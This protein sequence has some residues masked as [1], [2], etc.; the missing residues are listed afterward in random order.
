MAVMPIKEI[1]DPVLR[2]EAKKVKTVDDNTRELIKNL[3]DTLRENDGLGL[4]ANQIGILQ[5][6][7]VVEVENELLKI[8]NPEII[9]KKG[10]EIGEEGC[11]S[12]PGKQGPVSRAK[13]ITLSYQNEQGLEVE[14]TFTD[15]V[16]RVI[17]HEIDHLQGKLFV[18]KIVDI[19]SNLEIDD[20]ARELD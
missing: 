2:T 3:I 18:D 17:Q 1:G 12:V 20:K 16:A 19:S 11:L 10:K 5:Q 15:L 6:V 9:D 8:I 4:A 7:A 14:K 13:E